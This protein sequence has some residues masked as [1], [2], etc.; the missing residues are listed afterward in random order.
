MRDGEPERLTHDV[1]YRHAPLP[2]DPFK[3][4]SFH[5]RDPHFQALIARPVSP[6][7][8]I[9]CI[10]VRTLPVR[11]DLRAVRAGED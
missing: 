5:S 4:L 3:L 9:R 2:R 7:A 1:R 6:V 11:P 8:M 10:Y